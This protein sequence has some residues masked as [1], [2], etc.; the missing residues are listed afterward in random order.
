M[1]RG[2]DE[3]GGWRYRLG[4]GSVLVGIL[5]GKAGA[6]ADCKIDNIE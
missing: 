2:V 5:Q 4:S 6:I 1:N 3:D